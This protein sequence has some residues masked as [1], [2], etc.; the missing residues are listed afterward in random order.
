MIHFFIRNGI[1]VAVFSLTIILFGF[2]ALFHLPIQLIPD[3]SAPTVTVSTT[4]PGAS[5]E[6]VEQDILIEQERFLRNLPGL[7]KMVSTASFSN[8]EINLEFSLETD[9][10]ENLIRVNNALSQVPSYPENVDEPRLKTAT[11]DEMPVAWI[12]VRAIQNSGVSVLD[13]FDF[14]EDFV[15]TEFERLPGV[16]GVRGVFGG[17]SREMQ[18]MLD[19]IKLAERGIAITKVRQ[20]IRTRNRDVSGGDLD[21][22]KRRFNVR[23]L[24]RFHSPADIEDV[25]IAQVDG[26]PV[27]LRDVGFARLGQAEQRTLIRQ[28]GKRAF[29]LGVQRERGSNLLI[30][31]DNIK[32]T[33]NQ[34]NQGLLQQHS[35]YL[36]QVTDD[37][38]YVKNA[39]KM[40]RSNLLY[41]GLLA[42]AVLL[43]FLRRPR[44]T[45]IISMTI[46]LCILGSFFIINASG[47]SINV[48]SLA[49]L[50]F[51]I[52]VI[53]DA[54][55]VVLENIFRHRQAGK[56]A[57]D[58]AHDGTQEVWTAILA[59]TL[60]NVI[61]FAP[62]ITLA[63][64]AGQ[65]FRDIAIAIVSAN[66]LALLVSIVVI[67]ALAARLLT[68]EA[69][70]S[71]KQDQ[72]RLHWFSAITTTLQQTYKSILRKLLTWLLNGVLRRV[73]I[74][75]LILTIAIICSLRF[76]PKTEYLPEGN[77][78]SIIAIII[79]PQGYGIK[80]MSAIGVELEKRI[81]PQ[82]EAS[83]SDYAEGRINKPPMS[84]FFFAAFGNNMFVFTRA[85][86]AEQAV[87]VPEAMRTVLSDVPGV[88]AI[89]SQRSI[90]GG[91]LTGS[92]SIELDIIGPDVT[93][94]T[95]IASA[96]FF[97]ILKVLPGAQPRPLPGIE[98]GQ[99]QITI[100]PDWH[101]AN[102]LGI[103]ANTLG[104]N[105][106][107]LGNGAYADDYYQDGDKMD[108][109]LYSTP[110][111]FTNLA[112]FES[113]RFATEN[114]DSIA[115]NEVAKIEFD[116]GP[117]QIRRVDFR[118]TVTLKVVPP[119]DKALEESIEIIEKQ[120]I[121]ALNDQGLVPKDYAIN[122]GGTSNKLKQIKE[123]LR[124]DF[125]L[126]LILAYLTMVLVFKHWGH[127]L[128]VMLSVPIGISGGVLGLVLL[129][130]YL[131]I[132]MPGAIQSLDVLTM[133][134][135]VILL[136]S[137]INNPI[138]IV[139]QS[140]NFINQ[141]M[142]PHKAI[143]ESTL[144]RVR[145][146]MMTTGTTIF[147]LMPL[148]LNPGA[149]SELYR[150]LGAVMF[151]GLLLGA[152]TTLF[153]IPCLMS[154]LMDLYAKFRD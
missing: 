43:I 34:L 93:M 12:S 101:K 114:G 75:T 62:I 3:I 105:I 22:G 37:T 53:L 137:V 141:Q 69:D 17:T 110:A 107:V 27:Y 132:V 39:V 11:A 70:V 85:R 100:K 4:Y 97:Q 134:G 116:Y 111:A 115:L 125:F 99:P 79:P 88:I 84:N 56:S 24:G 96:A 146:I 150:G 121:K 122:I 126:A 66:V 95:T 68:Q 21:E 5:P 30:L 148:V 61:V 86:K 73:F 7:K 54:S 1:G 8:A 108:I 117:Q 142:D 135:F 91:D 44:P 80:E 112:M 83:L 6:D 16:A 15:K 9:K 36:T 29:G 147:G 119:K 128:T 140:L 51:S 113:L 46:P 102:E 123:N 98:M 18:V 143:I 60:T 90:F 2:I 136:G 52:G 78:Q 76:L 42:V 49:G 131:A 87:L 82:L 23:T 154:L 58:A 26:A 74:V 47:R 118:R 33:I 153:F 92:R 109:Y 104:Y 10:Q 129:N 139:Q 127:P 145:P 124:A 59:S 81:K 35:L 106:A 14:V 63:N 72:R 151:G 40:V 32:S 13:K 144:T 65:I 41:G 31:M 64:E 152:I 55:I 50:A 133:L 89:A 94:L 45:F 71:N 25:V 149:G 120:V 138:L 28:N 48:I 57:I 19:P 130:E 77:Q 20:A 67:P 38:T 103:N